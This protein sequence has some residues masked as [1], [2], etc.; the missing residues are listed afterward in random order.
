MTEKAIH[1]ERYPTFD[2]PESKLPTNQDIPSK[3]GIQENIQG[4]KVVKNIGRIYNS[5]LKYC[6]PKIVGK[7]KAQDTFAA[8]KATQDRIL[9]LREIKNIYHH[10]NNL[11]QAVMACVTLTRRCIC[12]I[13]GWNKEIPT[14]RNLNC[15]SKL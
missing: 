7:L 8:V 2:Y 5:L 13:S 12:S 9:L 4:R 10:H 1:I 11:K 15:I 3:V 14:I 6:S